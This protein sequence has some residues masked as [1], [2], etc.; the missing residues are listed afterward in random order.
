MLIIEELRDVFQLK[1]PNRMAVGID[2]PWIDGILGIK[3]EKIC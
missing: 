3:N 1:H 2:E